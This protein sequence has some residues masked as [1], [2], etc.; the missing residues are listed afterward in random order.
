MCSTPTVVE[1]E[2]TFL[3][4]FMLSHETHMAIAS[5]QG[6]SYCMYPADDDVLYQMIVTSIAMAFPSHSAYFVLSLLFSIFNVCTHIGFNYLWYC[7]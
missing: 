2:I 6:Q 5:H 4:M 1:C 7:T 3:S